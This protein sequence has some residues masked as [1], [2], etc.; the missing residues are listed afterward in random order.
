MIFSVLGPLFRLNIHSHFDVL[1]DFFFTV[2]STVEPGRKTADGEE[3][4]EESIN[5][6]ILSEINIDMEINKEILKMGDEA[7][8]SVET[9]DTIATKL[10]EET[11][12]LAAACSSTSANDALTSNGNVIDKTIDSTQN[13]TEENVDIEKV[14]KTDDLTADA[15]TTGVD[16]IKVDDIS[17]DLKENELLEEDDKKSDAVDSKTTTVD[18]TDNAQIEKDLNAEI[19]ADI[20]KIEQP[21]ADDSTVEI[22]PEVVVDEISKVL[23]NNT[24]ETST[25]KENLSAEIKSDV[26]IK[27]DGAL[28]GNGD[29]KLEDLENITDALATPAKSIEKPLPLT[30]TEKHPRDDDEDDNGDNDGHN[31]KKIRLDVKEID[32]KAESEPPAEIKI[33]EKSSET[34][35][36]VE[37]PITESNDDEIPE[38]VKDATVSETKVEPLL[39]TSDS[40]IA[41]VSEAQELSV[42]TEKQIAV[43]DEVKTKIE[44]PLIEEKPIENN[45]AIETLTPKLIDTTD[46]ASIK[47]DNGLITAEA[48]IPEA[49][50]N[51]L[52]PGKPNELIDVPADLTANINEDDLSNAVSGD[53]NIAIA[54]KSVP[55]NQEC[56]T[57]EET[58]GGTIANIAEED[59]ETAMEAAP[60]KLDDEQ[61]DVDES[62]SNDPMDL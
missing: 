38:I 46:E 53:D 26:Q 56:M 48:K 10:N 49:G 12:E 5:G 61:M 23:E 50:I 42:D 43:A 33:E 1:I 18:T 57:V 13:A 44:A 51:D 21:I 29:A 39:E 62:N 37:L 19:S 47:N 4:G 31:A 41:N 28:N 7:N 54:T 14:V 58:E 45:D 32:N 24:I 55:P 30:P 36:I 27:T 11:A 60:I 15:A 6:D 34:I 2:V 8:G 3:N 20:S 22:K 25:M 59:A 16:E 40:V 35:P 52:I 9:I 17:V